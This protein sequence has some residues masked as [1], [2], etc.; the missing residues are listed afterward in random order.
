MCSRNSF[1]SSRLTDL[2]DSDLPRNEISRIAE[3]IRKADSKGILTIDGESK[4]GD[5][6]GN[7]EEHAEF[8]ISTESLIET[9]QSLVDLTPEE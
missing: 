7:G 2:I 6:L 8:Y 1:A 4:I 9:L 3:Q 5:T